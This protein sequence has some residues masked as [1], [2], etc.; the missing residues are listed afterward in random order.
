M[1]VD[2]TDL[3]AGDKVRITRV[4]NPAHPMTGE[5]RVT[6]VG[7]LTKVTG[8]ASTSTTAVSTPGTPV[9]LAPKPSHERKFEMPRIY[10]VLGTD[11]YNVLV[12]VASPNEQSARRSVEDANRH[13]A[14]RGRPQ[15][16]RAEVA[17]IE[18]R[19]IDSD[20]W[21]AEQ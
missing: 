18:W 12:E 8:S 20:V 10:R 5:R 9:R 7:V 11:A 2:H 21:E 19:P 14:K 1:N 16:W 4:F 13:A 6:T 17:D 3:H 15:D